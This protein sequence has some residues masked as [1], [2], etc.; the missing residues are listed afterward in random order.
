MQE[1]KGDVRM[2]D[3]GRNEAKALH[4]NPYLRQA[5]NEASFV[6]RK[7]LKN[8]L[9]ILNNIDFVS[10]RDRQPLFYTQLYSQNAV[11]NKL[12]DAGIEI[13]GSQLP[14]FPDYY[15]TRGLNGQPNGIMLTAKTL[16]EYFQNGRSPNPELPSVGAIHLFR[17]L[18][19]LVIDE[20]TPTI[21][22][23]DVPDDNLVKLAYGALKQIPPIVNRP[24]DPKLRTVL[25]ELHEQVS[26]PKNLE[27]KA[28]GVGVKLELNGKILDYYYQNEYTSLIH[29]AFEEAEENF[30]RR[31]AK[32]KVNGRRWF[33]EPNR[34][35][36]DPLNNPKQMPEYQV[37]KNL[38]GE[39]NPLSALQKSDV[40][41]ILLNRDGV[42]ENH[43]IVEPTQELIQKFGIDL[44]EGSEEELAYPD[45]ND[46]FEDYDSTPRFQSIRKKRKGSL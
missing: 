25:R 4:D 28:K 42:F 37:V 29:L 3:K 32:Q 19:D 45:I 20:T 12:M 33:I 22:V 43:D 46:E 10:Y 14:P 15:V 1:F 35:T 24:G 41:F 21:K 11:I 38:L 30:I 13:R 36:R 27:L 40:A 44:E 26:D 18:A 17:T 9:P 16:T 23:D 5:V 31:L 39:F 34:W 7:N 2:I 8:D 6:L